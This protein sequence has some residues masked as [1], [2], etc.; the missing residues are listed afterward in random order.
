MSNPIRKQKGEPTYSYAY[1]ELGE[2]VNIN[3]DFLDKEYC[4][5][6]TFHCIDKE[7]G[8]EMY[9]TL[10]NDK[11]CRYFAHK[12][13]KCSYDHYLHTLAEDM[14]KEA[15]D[16]AE[17]FTL[18]YK[19]EVSC[20][21][22]DCPL[23]V[24]RCGSIKQEKKVNLKKWYDH[25]E[26]E[27]GI[28]GKY[29]EKY[30]A[31]ILLTS[32]K[33]NVP[34]LLLEIF[35]THPCPLDKR[36]SGL[37]I[38]ELKI[39]DES[40]IEEICSSKSIHES[41]DVRLY[42]FERNKCEKS[43]ID[44]PRYVH[45]PDGKSIME[46]VPCNT[47]AKIMHEDSDLEIN[48]FYNV[49]AEDYY[50][51]DSFVKRYIDQ[52]YGLIG[53]VPEYDRVISGTIRRIKLT[54]VKGQ[55]PQDNV[56]MLYGPHK[57]FNPEF[58]MEHIV[59]YL[60]GTD[61]PGRILFRTFGNGDFPRSVLG[62]AEKLFFFADFEPEDWNKDGKSAGYNC[63]KRLLNGARAVIIFDNGKDK[64]TQ[65]VIE[66]AKKTNR[67]TYIV[68]ITQYPD[69]CPECGWPVVPKYGKYGTFYACSHYPDCN[70]IRKQHN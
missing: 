13:G 43:V 65:Y 66:E 31:D 34:P 20:N 25:C 17:E 46:Y 3:A 21:Q 27:K 53:E 19:V 16:A 8:G 2:R 60:E 47:P 55:L 35:V 12:T 10:K 70:Y 18:T 32:S 52:R 41:E 33:P 38:A 57:F 5:Q 26:K 11:K 42:H 58:M 28:T 48:A 49:T 68:D 50:F 9:A 30:V 37:K 40:D 1:N 39:E 64:L 15:F 23:R 44:I 61:H 54:P 4:K 56:I 22:K 24:D 67:P 69:I 45:Y 36:A 63:A 51:N 59:S 29:G 14:I 7:C 62:V 6:H